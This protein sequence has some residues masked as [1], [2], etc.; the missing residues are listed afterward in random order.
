MNKSEVGR[1]NRRDLLKAA[2][3]LGGAGA[4]ARP[5]LGSA[6]S[7][8]TVRDRLW[9]WSH[10]AG[11]YNGMFGLPGKTRMTPVEAAFY[12]SIPNVYMLHREGTPEPPL[13][14]YALAFESLR[15]VVW[16]IV[17]EGGLTT[18]TDQTTILDLVLKT[19]KIA[20][21]VMD[22]FF[23][24]SF[25]KKKEGSAANLTVEGVRDLGQRL[26]GAHKRLEVV[27]YEYQLEYSQ[28]ALVVEYLKLCDVIQLWTWYPEHLG[29]LA[30]NFE[31]ARNLVPGARMA[32]GLYWWDLVN[33]RP[34]PLPV[35]RQQCELGM[36]LLQR[37][38]IEA[39]IFCGSWLCDRGLE[40]VNWT[41]QWIRQ[42][43]GK[44]VPPLQR[45]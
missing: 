21:A 41:R 6:T 3:V 1:W 36:E 40:A 31:K 5:A 24:D 10:V 4:L 19:P 7:P 23:Q 2:T 17:G 12:M 43:G 42:V 22:D 35:M 13:E 34:L 29:Q 44:R 8:A 25:F 39:L 33:N 14:Q 45:A 11:S 27:L 32:L 28:E 18:T 30:A 16:G 38:R 20:G 37:G 26:R 9:L 15:E